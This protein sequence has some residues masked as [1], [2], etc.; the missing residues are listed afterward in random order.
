MKKMTRIL[1]V[2]LLLAILLSLLP[3][4][5]AQSGD[6]L[7]EST[8]PSTIPLEYQGVPTMHM[9][10]PKVLATD[11]TLEQNLSMVFMTSE[12][13]VIIVDGGRKY[14]DADYLFAYLQKITGK[15]KPHVDAWFFTHA[16]TDHVG[17]FH[18][19]ANSYADRITVDT[20]YHHFPT[21][22][23]IATY[24]AKE[25]DP[26]NLKKKVNDVL[27]SA[28]KLKNTSGGAPS[29]KKVNSHHSGKTNSWINIDDISVEVVACMDDMIWGYKNVTGTF[30]GTLEN[31]NAVFNN[32][33]MKDLISKDFNN[34][35][36]VYRFH[37]AGR[38]VLIM[39]DIAAGGGIILGKLHDK[40]ASDSSQYFSLKSDMVQV[41]HH[42]R[43]KFPKSVYTKIGAKVAL[44][45]TTPQN[46]NGPSG[47]S[48]YAYYTRQWLKDCKTYLAYDGPYAFPFGSD[49]LYF[50]FETDAEA[51]SRYNNGT[52]GMLNFSDVKYWNKGPDIKKANISAGNMVLTTAATKTTK[53]DSYIETSTAMSTD[54]TH[55]LGYTPKVG[56][57]VMIRYKVDSYDPATN[58]KIF[59]SGIA[60]TL[61]LYASDNGTEVYDKTSQKT[62]DTSGKYVVQK[63]TVPESWTNYN[64]TNIH[65]KTRYFLN[66]TM[67]LDYIYVGP[68]PENHLL[69]DFEDTYESR[70]RYNS[71][72]YGFYNFSH[73][74][75]WTPGQS[76]FNTPEIS[77]GIMKLTPSANYAAYGWIQTGATTTAMPLNYYP[78]ETDILQM[79]F[80]VDNVEASNTVEHMTGKGPSSKPAGSSGTLG[81]WGPAAGNEL[82]LPG[83]F[84]LP[85]VKV[86]LGGS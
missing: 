86:L 33:T 12:G 56:D 43:G 83:T 15:E 39:G 34:S 45:P 21:D 50:D 60:P 7:Q 23:E 52:Y 27:A 68:E 46:Y 24:F 14:A 35:S 22:S 20:I 49:S 51:V 37:I 61:N 59:G 72:A 80:K 75:S 5:Y 57:V 71:F 9:L 69:F 85:C 31:N 48:S 84:I 47:S 67:R 32:W 81:Y 41:S 42:G 13:R 55:P 28:A 82:D 66:S 62:V 79:R 64:I 74:G 1:S 29:I 10:P 73:A 19:I 58:A 76:Y 53:A 54:Q 65:F 36:T 38:T 26:E 40:N 77:D 16:H 30:S 3:T 78:Q 63:W 25:D 70:E 8:V 17:C 18:T 44:W 6:S 11:G 4:V 2:L